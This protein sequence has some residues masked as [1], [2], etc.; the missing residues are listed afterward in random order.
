MHSKPFERA[1]LGCCTHSPESSAQEA[2]FVDL[3][4]SVKAVMASPV[5]LP[6]ATYRIL[7][8]E[9]SSA[10]CPSEC[11]K[12]FGFVQDGLTG[13]DCIRC[14]WNGTARCSRCY[15]RMRRH[16]PPDTITVV[17]DD[18]APSHLMLQLISLD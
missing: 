8:S 10:Q 15:G 6:A 11:F 5:E 18:P 14:P 2:V 7:E 9:G 13:Q 3:V 1:L 16:K 12:H 4:G 17:A